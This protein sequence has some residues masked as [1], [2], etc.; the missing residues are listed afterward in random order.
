MTEFVGVRMIGPGLFHQPD[1]PRPTDQPK[2]ADRPSRPAAAPVLA[3]ARCPADGTVT[4]PMQDSCPRCG[5]AMSAVALPDH[6]LLWS[7]TVQHVRPKPPYRPQDSEF[8]AFAVGY[9]D[10][11][12]VI[13]E[14][15]LDAGPA[16]LAIGMPMRLCW[17]PLW[18][19]AGEQV[20]GYAFAPSDGSPS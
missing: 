11:G 18:Q 13:V 2:P 20:L 4:F 17:Q 10:L 9:V 5:L 3:G 15:R 7:W 1:R 16:E 6:G 14:A 19:E 12:E 8:T